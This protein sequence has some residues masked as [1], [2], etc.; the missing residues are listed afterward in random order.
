MLHGSGR[1]RT[2]NAT[3]QTKA[4]AAT[5]DHRAETAAELTTLRHAAAQSIELRGCT[6]ARESPK[7]T[8]STIEAEEGA[9]E[10]SSMGSRNERSQRGFYSFG[11]RCGQ[12]VHESGAAVTLCNEGRCDWSRAVRTR[13]AA[14]DAVKAAAW[15]Q[16]IEQ[17]VAMRTAA[18]GGTKCA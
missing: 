18:H 16:Y 10:D 15:E 6:D 11:A 3:L 1:I 2:R 9:L 13:W 14:N 5:R 4:L 8:Y 17:L 7:M 12:P